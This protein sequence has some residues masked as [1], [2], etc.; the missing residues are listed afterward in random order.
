MNNRTAILVLLVLI[1]IYICFINVHNN[2]HLTS[3]EAVTNIASLYNS[4]TLT[5]GTITSTGPMT[6]NNNLSIA[7]TA[8]INGETTVGSLKSQGNIIANN[9]NVSNTVKTNN[10]VPLTEETLSIGGPKNNVDI[11]QKY[12]TLNGSNV[13]GG[14]LSNAYSYQDLDHAIMMCKGS[15]RCSTIWTNGSQF[16]LKEP[17]NWDWIVGSPKWSNNTYFTQDIN[18]TADKVINAPNF[19]ACPSS[20]MLTYQMENKRL[21]FINR[22]KNSV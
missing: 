14:D 2:E 10:I 21:G 12:Y 8:V 4:N 9:I 15:P 22:D 18:L 20:K 6:S 1:F 5:A 11:V 3:L 13:N 19:T 7:G 17:N 16:W